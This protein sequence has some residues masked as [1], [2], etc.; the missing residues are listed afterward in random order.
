MS[1]HLEIV[2]W[3]GRSF[4]NDENGQNLHMIKSISLPC[5]DHTGIYIVFRYHT[6]NIFVFLIVD[7][8]FDFWWSD[9]LQRFAKLLKT[10]GTFVL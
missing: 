7:H 10:R 9:L 4:Q 2:Y 1:G 5:A 3:S 6:G 8:V